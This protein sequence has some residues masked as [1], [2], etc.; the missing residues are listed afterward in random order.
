M[1]GQKC[2]GT[3]IQVRLYIGTV[4]KMD[5]GTWVLSHDQWEAYRDCGG[6]QIQCGIQNIFGG[7]V[8]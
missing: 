1:T 7:Q 3:E 5:D 4:K 2:D 8:I 6:Q